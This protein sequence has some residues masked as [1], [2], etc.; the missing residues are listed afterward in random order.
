MINNNT[1]VGFDDQGRVMIT[2]HKY[3]ARGDTQ[4]FVARRER[5]GWVTAQVTHWKGFRWDFHGYG[6]LDSRL[7]VKGPQPAGNDL[8]RVSVVRD[9]APIDLLIDAKTLALVAEQP[10]HTLAATLA[11]R[12]P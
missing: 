10:R 12:L 2:Y 11:S 3:D 5:K 4:I 9:G 8:L 1:V 6:S 7:F